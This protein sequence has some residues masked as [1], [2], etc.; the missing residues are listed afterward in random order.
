MALIF[1]GNSEIRGRV[2]LGF[3]LWNFL[4]QQ[5]NNKKCIF[6]TRAQLV[7]SFHLVQSYY[8]I[9]SFVLCRTFGRW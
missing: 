1:D 8:S 9:N 2:K 5:I 3:F 7:L 4:D 6:F